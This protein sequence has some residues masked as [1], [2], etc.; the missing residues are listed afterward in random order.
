MTVGDLRAQLSTYET[1]TATDGL[2]SF[3]LRSGDDILAALAAAEE[4]LVATVECPSSTHRAAVNVTGPGSEAF[5]S[6]PTCR[7]CDGTGT[8]RI[9]AVTEDVLRGRLEGL[10]SLLD[11]WPEGDDVVD[12]IVRAL[13]GEAG[14]E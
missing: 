12:R 6:N 3:K 10:E 9:V 2:P 4:P 13:L 5:L 14:D 7:D 11:E 1:I 8:V